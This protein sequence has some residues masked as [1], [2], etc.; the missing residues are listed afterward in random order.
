MLKLKNYIILDKDRIAI[1]AELEQK[2]KLNMDLNNQI[3]LL[4]NE[5]LEKDK[6]IESS[7]TKAKELDKQME[8]KDITL[9]EMYKKNNSLEQEK[10]QLFIDYQ[11]KIEELQLQI[12]DSASNAM[13]ST[14][15]LCKVIDILNSNVDE[16]KNIFKK[17]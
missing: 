6:I 4:E 16:F 7:E 5:C 15:G 3:Q 1:I 17:K 9:D 13:D 8:I 12:L 2:N 14:S 11:K 10:E